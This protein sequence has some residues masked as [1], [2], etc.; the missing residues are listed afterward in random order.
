M[1]VG[2]S[3]AVALAARGV[4]PTTRT[5]GAAERPLTQGQDHPRHAASFEQAPPWK[6]C[7]LGAVGINIPASTRPG[8]LAP[9]VF[10]P[11][12]EVLGVNLTQPVPYPLERTSRPLLNH[13]PD[14]EA[15]RGFNASTFG[16]VRRQTNV[17]LAKGA[18]LQLQSLSLCS[19]NTPS[20]AGALARLRPIRCRSGGTS[21]PPWFRPARSI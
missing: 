18:M 7:G 3:G 4:R 9:Q 5:S 16:Q 8:V 10:Q 21:L 12:V 20:G 15:G 13:G 19:N 11:R 17:A 2:R 14:V 1:T 6:P